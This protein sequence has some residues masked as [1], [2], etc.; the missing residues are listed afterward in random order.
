M[1]NIKNSNSPLTKSISET[2]VKERKVTL[3]FRTKN[4]SFH[5]QYLEN[6][7]NEKGININTY[8]L[9]LIS[10]H[11]EDLIKKKYIPEFTTTLYGVTRKAVYAG[12][13]GQNVYTSK[14]LKPIME[15]TYILDHKVNLIL[16][17]LLNQI[18]DKKYKDL[19]QPPDRYLEE[20][21]KFK[22]LRTRLE[23]KFNKNIINYINKTKN[24]ESNN[25]KFAS[26][27][28]FEEYVN[29]EEEK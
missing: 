23:N 9:N 1:S 8:L 22:L 2:N 15:N 19:Q 17:I 12:T 13:V 16:N 5:H 3:R 14:N 25:S 26:A 11:V 4:Q 6:L 21:D 7:C 27:V 20:L 29:S 18:D 10:S 28:S 24:T